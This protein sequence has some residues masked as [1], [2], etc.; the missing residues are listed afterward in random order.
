ML[1]YD[2][3]Y[4][5]SLPSTNSFLKECAKNGASE[6]KVAFAYTQTGGKGSN[7]RKFYSP[8]S[9]L[10]FSVLLRPK[11]D[12]CLYLTPMAAVAVAKAIEDLGFNGV[13]IKWVNDI[14]L[15]GKKVCGILTEGGLDNNKEY[16]AVLGIGINFS[17]PSGGFPIDIQNTATY[18]YQSADDNLRQNLFHS[19]LNNLSSLYQNLSE[20]SFLS[21]YREKS[22][23]TGKEVTITNNLE[24]FN[25]IVIG[26]SD[27]FELLVKTSQ[28]QVLTL[29]SGDVVLFAQ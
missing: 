17:M 10:Y 28:N 2:I 5:D 3:S 24:T 21:Y 26:I 16:Y 23:L 15:N 22:Y 25:G 18:L 19:I 20:K 11:F 9:G 27:N 6:G 7:G 14:F 1:N 13:A 29:N 8:D 4:Y 12:Q